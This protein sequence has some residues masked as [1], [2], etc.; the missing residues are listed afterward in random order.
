MASNKSS[1]IST[2]LD[3]IIADLLKQIA[4]RNGQSISVLLRNIINEYLKTLI[5]QDRSIGAKSELN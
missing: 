3:P 5:P 2:V 1:T 4:I